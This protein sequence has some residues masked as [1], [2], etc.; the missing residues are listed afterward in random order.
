M[1]SWIG[2]FLFGRVATKSSFCYYHLLVECWIATN[3]V[4]W[5]GSFSSSLEGRRGQH[6]CAFTKNELQAWNWTVLCC[7][8]DLLC[9]TLCQLQVSRLMAVWGGSYE[10]A[11]SPCWLGWCFISLS[12]LFGGVKDSEW[13]VLDR[14]DRELAW[15]SVYFPMTAWLFCSCSVHYFSWLFNCLVHDWHH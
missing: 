14:S 8:A 1:L 15:S 6:C 7:L 11:L 2:F 9:S 3:F 10:S 5:W 4:V 12:L 13:Y